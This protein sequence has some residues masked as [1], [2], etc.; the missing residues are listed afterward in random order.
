MSTSAAAGAAQTKVVLPTDMAQYNSVEK[1]LEWAK[2]STEKWKEIAG[3]LGD[4]TLN[5]LPTIAM[6]NVDDWR[7]AA[8]KISLNPIMKARLGLFINVVR[9]VQGVAHIDLGVQPPAAAP[10]PVPIITVNAPL[11][12]ADD[13]ASLRVKDFF[14]QASKILVKTADAVDLQKMRDRWLALKSLE[15]G[16]NVDL[17]D[18][19]LSVL[20]RL[21]ELGHNLL[22]FDMGVW[23]PYS[24]RRERAQSVTVHYQ[25]AAGK[26]I[27]KEIGGAQCLDDWLD[28]WAFA[29]SGFVMCDSVTEGVADAYR[30]NFKKLCGFYPKAW[31]ICCQADWEFRHEFAPAEL[32]RQKSFHDS[33]PSMSSFDPA[34]PWNSV[35]LAG[36]T[37]LESMQFWTDHLKERARKWTES[38]QADAEPSWVRRQANLYQAASQ[39][40][41]AAPVQ[42]STPFQ[43]Q[44]PPPKPPGS[45]R[46]A[47]K[48]KQWEMQDATVKGSW[49]DQRRPDGGFRYSA[50]GSEICYTWNRFCDGCGPT[51]TRNPPRAHVCELCRVPHKAIDCKAN[52]NWTPPAPKGDGKKGSKKGKGGKY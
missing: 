28:A 34:K 4:D 7:D 50:E 45:G 31:W 16:A 5:D 36:T 8:A 21:G 3:A 40:G 43:S 18:N 41:Q 12:A 47:Q 23:G 52:P 27:P 1:G 22:A 42:Q 24:E 17:A 30:D 10:A 6:I 2:L 48:R 26:W 35:L 14:D 25:N 46:R 32:R 51:C 29:T 38:G 37:G 20:F 15:P 11:S 44:P 9:Q 39:A 49:V 33:N 13:P 19:Q